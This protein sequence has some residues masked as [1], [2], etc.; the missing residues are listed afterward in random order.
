MKWLFLAAAI[1]AGVFAGTM[2]ATHSATLWSRGRSVSNTVWKVAYDAQYKILATVG[3]LFAFGIV[4]GSIAAIVSDQQAVAAQKQAAAADQEYQAE[5]TLKGNVAKA[6][7]QVLDMDANAAATAYMAFPTV[8]DAKCTVPGET[9]SACIARQQAPY[10]GLFTAMRQTQ[11]DANTCR[12]HLQHDYP[13]Q[14]P[15]PM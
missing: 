8:T 2:L 7:C 5:R 15:P 10:Q 12:Y 11:S 4:V 13:E 1:A 14:V 9:L 3:I 6:H